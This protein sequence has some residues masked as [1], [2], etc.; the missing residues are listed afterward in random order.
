MH[1]D[2]LEAGKRELLEETG[3]VAKEWT[4]ILTM[5]L[6]NSVS[7]EL[8][9]IYLARDIEM[10]TSAPEETEQLVIKKLHFD[11]VTDM[12]RNGEITDSMSVASILQILFM[13]SRGEIK[14]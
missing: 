10:Q 7:D 11:E 12:M 9:V 5:H 14:K 2:P 13:I 6:S 8:S 4:K 3:L 1:E